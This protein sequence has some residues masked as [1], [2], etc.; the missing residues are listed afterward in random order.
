MH[1]PALKLLECQ[2][3][4]SELC[5]QFTVAILQSHVKFILPHKSAMINS[6]LA[7]LR[8]NILSS[9]LVASKLGK[10]VASHFLES[11]W[12]EQLLLQ[13][14]VPSH[15]LKFNFSE[16]N[17]LITLIFQLFILHRAKPLS[18]FKDWRFTHFLPHEFIGF[19]LS[20]FTDFFLKF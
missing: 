4:V 1:D 2:F 3:L 16:F 15:L 10:D 8:R 6:F 9:P 20:D 18:L 13:L 7:Q 19:V 14:L 5:E 12:V 11:F 17:F